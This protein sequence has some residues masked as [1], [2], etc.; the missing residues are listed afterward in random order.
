[1][2]TRLI[3][4]VCVALLAV[5][6]GCGSKPSDET[7]HGLWYNGEK[8]A[9]FLPTGSTHSFEI[10]KPPFCVGY[11]IKPDGT[12][13]EIYRLLAIPTDPNDP[14]VLDR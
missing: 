8:I 3:L 5:A 6:G 4:I 10:V 9:R 13:E 7:H 2:K 12:V 14:R 11:K 1:M